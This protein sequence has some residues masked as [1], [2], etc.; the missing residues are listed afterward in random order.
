MK[1]YQ[2]SLIGDGAEHAGYQYFSNQREAQKAVTHWCKDKS[3]EHDA[4][5][6]IIDVEITKRGILRLLNRYASHADNG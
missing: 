1:V 5:M 2:V 6:E 4:S 3:V